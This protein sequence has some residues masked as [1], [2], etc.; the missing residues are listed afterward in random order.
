MIRRPPRSSLFPYTTLFRSVDRD[1]Q[2]LGAEA[3]RPVAHLVGE[4][5]GQRV[6]DI[7][8]VNRRSEKHTHELQSRLPVVCRLPLQT[9]N[10]GADLGPRARYLRYCQLV[11]RFG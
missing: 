11:I 10:R 2:G 5:V 7:E 9:I 8:G 3:T 4:A 6:A 1:G